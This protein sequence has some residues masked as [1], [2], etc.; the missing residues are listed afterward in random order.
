MPARPITYW[1]SS[2]SDKKKEPSL[3]ANASERSNPLTY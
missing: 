1:P 2:E 3:R